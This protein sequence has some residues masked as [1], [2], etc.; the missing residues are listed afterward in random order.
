MDA[1]TLLDSATLEVQGDVLT[2]TLGQK[3]LKAKLPRGERGAAGR[4]GISIKGDKGEQ[5][6]QGRDGQAGRDSTIAG[7]RG[8]KG[9]RGAIGITPRFTIGR[10]VTGDEASAVISGTAEEPI[11]NLVLPRGERGM[12]GRDGVKGKDGNHEYIQLH[13]AGSS[14]RFTNE[15]ITNHCLVDGQLDLPDMT[16][17]DVGSWTILKTFTDLVV[18]GCVEGCVRVPRGEARK[19]VVIAYG[20]KHQFTGF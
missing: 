13:Y 19:F 14:P 5:G 15:F 20:G 18:N 1:Q 7:E 3:G 4:D 10:V 6:I 16:E 9:E 8:E 2:L 12:A 11:L 17:S